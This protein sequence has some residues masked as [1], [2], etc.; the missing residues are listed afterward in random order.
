[1]KA[2]ILQLKN[3]AE[4]QDDYLKHMCGLKPFM[5]CDALSSITESTAEGTEDDR[6]EASFANMQKNAW[7]TAMRKAVPAIRVKVRN[8]SR[9]SPGAATGKARKAERAS[10]CNEADK[11]EST[12]KSSSSK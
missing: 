2:N 5:A 8:L 3:R 11:H 1:M 12:A 9:A 7:N 6:S 4:H 10:K